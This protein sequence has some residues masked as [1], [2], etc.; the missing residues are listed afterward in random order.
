MY[1]HRIISLVTFSTIF[2]ITELLSAGVAWYFFSSY[3]LPTSSPTSIKPEPDSSSPIKAEGDGTESDT[4]LGPP[5]DLSDTPRD[6]PTYSRQP[7][8]RYT[9]KASIK[10]E[11]DDNDKD[12]DMATKVAATTRIQPLA[13]LRKTDDEDEDDEADLVD[14]GSAMRSTKTDSG[15]GT[16]LDEGRGGAAAGAG[17]Q[18]RRSSGKGARGN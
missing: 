1:N 5:S 15:I 9:G 18:R 14:V 13:N 2:W 11:E 10:K 12:D 8:L 4:N 3:L 16:S 7:P 6:F 17:L